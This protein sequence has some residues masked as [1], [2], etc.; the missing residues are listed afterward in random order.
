MNL[1]ERLKQL[2]NNWQ[3]APGYAYRIM[4]GD[5]IEYVFENLSNILAV[6]EAAKDF[7]ASDGDY[8]SW[9]E[10]ERQ[11]LSRLKETLRVLE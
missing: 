11:C 7:L 5:E 9:T 8:F 3:N 6:V 4:R 10:D 2:S 1:L